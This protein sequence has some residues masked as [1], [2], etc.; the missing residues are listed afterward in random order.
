MLLWACLIATKEPWCIVVPSRAIMI[1]YKLSCMHEIIQVNI[2]GTSWRSRHGTRQS[3]MLLGACL[4]TREPWCIVVHSRA[5]M[6]ECRLSCMHDII[7]VNITGTSW[8]SRY[9]TRQSYILLG[10]CLATREPYGAASTLQIRLRPVDPL[11][12]CYA[13]R[14]TRTR[15]FACLCIPDLLF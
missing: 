8:R 4:A 11:V 13:P 9:G 10:A 3:Y 6:N 12:Y 14:Q 7:Q 1:E 15:R 2:T 5:I